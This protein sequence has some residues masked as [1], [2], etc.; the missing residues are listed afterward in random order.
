MR[1]CP[2]LEE[3]LR[4]GLGGLQASSGSSRG[5]G[6]GG[7]REALQLGLC[8]PPRCAPSL[9]TPQPLLQTLC[10]CSWSWGPSPGTAVPSGES[11]DSRAQDLTELSVPGGVGGGPDLQPSWPLRWGEP[12]ERGVHRRGELWVRGHTQTLRV[13]ARLPVRYGAE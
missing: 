1:K 5:Q 10:I 9:P 13:P 12:W 8:Q 7:D 3:V 4:A 6:L 11:R 2:E